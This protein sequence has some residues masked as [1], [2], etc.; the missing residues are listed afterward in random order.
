MDLSKVCLQYLSNT[1]SSKDNHS[2]KTCTLSVNI[3]SSKVL[4]GDTIIYVCYWRRDSHFARSSKP[5]EGLPVCRAK[6]VPS[7]T[8]YWSG[9]R[10]SNL[11]PSSLQSNALPTQLTLSLSFGLYIRCNETDLPLGS[12]LSFNRE[13]KHATTTATASKTSLNKKHRRSVKIY[14]L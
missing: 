9:P 11:R 1:C 4:I 14:P 10:E 2:I 6:E 7:Y 8:E 12:M 13:L 5:R 3:F